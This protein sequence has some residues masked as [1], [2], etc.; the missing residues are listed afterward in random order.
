MF[1]DK[2]TFDYSYI[3]KNNHSIVCIQFDNQIKMIMEIY[4]ILKLTK[5]KN[6]FST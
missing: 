5:E 6:T 1:V 2:V 3:V 4:V